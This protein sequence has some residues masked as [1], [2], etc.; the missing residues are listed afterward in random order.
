MSNTLKDKDFRRIRKAGKRIHCL[1][2]SAPLRMHANKSENY[3][4]EGKR[5]IYTYTKKD[6]YTLA[7]RRHSASHRKTAQKTKHRCIR[8]EKRSEK[9]KV[10]LELMQ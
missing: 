5:I 1:F 8:S 9:N 2:G 4:D 7:K 10:K 3:S 6:L